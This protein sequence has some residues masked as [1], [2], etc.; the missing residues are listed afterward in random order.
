MTRVMRTRLASRDPEQGAYAILY[1]LLVVVLVTL[2]AI[3]VDIADVRSDRRVDRSVTD[4]AS[5]AGADLLGPGGGSGPSVKAACLR[6]WQYILPA[7][8]IG[9]LPGSACTQFDSYQTSAAINTYCAATSAPWPT[10]IRDE[11][12]AGGRTVIVAWP[13]PYHAGT[14]VSEFLT[15]DIAPGNLN[16]N[17]SSTVDGT[18]NGCDRLGVAI[19]EDEAFRLGGGTDVSG[20]TTQVHSVARFDPSLGPARIVA[21]LNVLNV[22]ECRVM[23]SAG[24]GSILVDPVMSGTPPVPTQPG[25]IAVESSGTARNGDWVANCQAKTVVRSTGGG[26]ICASSVAIT[27][28]VACDGRG[29]IMMHEKDDGTNNNG[30]DP[31]AV[32]T[33][34]A[35]SLCPEPEPE[36]GTYRWNPVTEIYGC[37]T[38]ALNP[39]A[40]PATNHI[41]NLETAYSSGTPTAAYGGV[42]PYNT[43]GTSFY[44]GGFTTI[45]GGT[46]DTIGDGSS[47]PLAAGNYYFDCNG[48]SVTG[49]LIIQGGN[50]VLRAGNVTV[51]QNGCFVFNT[52]QATCPTAANGTI[53]GSGSRVTT[54]PAP[55]HDGILYLR[56][57]SIVSSGT[58]VMPQVFV[59]SKAGRLDIG[60]GPLTLWTA[61]GGGSLNG[62]GRTTLQQDCFSTATSTVNTDCMASRFSRVVYWSD[63]KVVAGGNTANKFVAQGTLNLVGVFFTP[64][65][66]FMF[67]GGNCLSAQATQFWT[68]DLTVEGQA[69]VKLRPDQEFSELR[70]PGAARLI[71]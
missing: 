28:T 20:T 69:C 48:L 6:A 13:I 65:G 56:G 35:D 34:P 9:S 52:A 70:P 71:R 63:A 59:Y 36:F 40:V 18:D 11:R 16:Q 43:N 17:F 27:S 39:C 14:T 57:G 5:V 24:G 31:D 12:V 49:T 41:A 19:F 21:A 29:K 22:D 23:D 8:K 38:T 66:A 54:D 1:A 30:Y 3:V 53:I 15:P 26:T 33:C 64:R 2:G 42:A 10:E 61:P 32:N 50:V 45:S 55:Q 37:N 44:G 67:A 60:G 58:T 46:C 62:S 7:L 47:P 25:V 51:G 68:D 4:S